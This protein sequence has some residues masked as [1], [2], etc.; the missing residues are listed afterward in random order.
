[1]KVGNIFELLGLTVVAAILIDIVTNRRTA[2]NVT[3]AG[4]AWSEI[5]KSAQGK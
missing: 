1:M 5:L 2:G 4:K 3:A